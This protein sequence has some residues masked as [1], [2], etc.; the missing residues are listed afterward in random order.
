MGTQLGCEYTLCYWISS[1][2][3]SDPLGPFYRWGCGLKARPFCFQSAAMLAPS[4]HQ[5]KLLPTTRPSPLLFPLPG[6]LLPSCGAPLQL[7]SRLN[8]RLISEA[9]LTA[10]A[11]SSLPLY[12][13]STSPGFIVFRV[14]VTFCNYLLECSCPSAPLGC[15][16]HGNGASLPC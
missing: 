13:L 5:A 3:R 8:C 2:L 9:T 16:H 11:E 12:G 1:R 14:L 15:K 10:P 4:H 7:G 6:A